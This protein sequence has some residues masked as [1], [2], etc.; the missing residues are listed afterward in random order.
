V[1]GSSGTPPAGENIRAAGEVMREGNL[2]LSANTRIGPPELGV[3]VA[4]G[5]AEVACLA[6]PS[7]HVLCTGDELREPG[8][9]LRAGEIHNSNGP[10]LVA[11]ARQAG[12]VPAGPELLA[13]EPA[14]IEAALARALAQADVVIVC[15]G[16]SVGPHDHV[17]PALAKLGVSQTFWGVALQ[18]GKPTWFG[19]HARQLVFG[20]PGNPVSVAV[21]FVLFVAPALQHL[22]GLGADPGGPGQALLVGDP[23]KRNRAREQALRVRLEHRDGSLLAVVNGPQG[24]HVL[25]SLLGADALALIPPGEGELAPGTAVALRPL[26]RY[27]VS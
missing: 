16:V 6:R 25:T 27:T 4:A 11:Y 14:D 13:D 18:P 24:S 10:M 21:T 3:A 12:A 5:V 1:A 8:A 22:S 15:G 2:V 23:V 26:P 19:S 7:V 9:R 20:L 17:K